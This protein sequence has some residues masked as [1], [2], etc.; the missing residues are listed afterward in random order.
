MNRHVLLAVCMA[1]VILGACAKESK[2]PK[3]T[4]EGAVRALNA[5]PA[6]PEIAFLIEERLL[7]S[8]APKTVTTTAVWDNLE[9]TFNF[10]T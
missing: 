7:G 8:A 9:Y 5:I 6:S 2:L 4:G 10:Q 1:A 3:A